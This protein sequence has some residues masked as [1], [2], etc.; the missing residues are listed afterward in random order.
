MNSTASPG[1]GSAGPFALTSP[2]FADGDAIPQRHGCS[3]EDVSP[4]LRWRGAP[5]GTTQLVL[6]VDDPDAGGFIHWLLAGIPAAP[7]GTLDEGRGDAST[8]AD[9]QGGN[10]FGRSGWGGPCPPRRHTYVF[11]LYALSEPIDAGPELTAGSVRAAMEGKV[12]GEARLSGTY[13]QGG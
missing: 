6:I 9:G 12:I 3:G 11:T 8:H 4:E 5:E 13:Q 1:A 7:D 2:A 10:D